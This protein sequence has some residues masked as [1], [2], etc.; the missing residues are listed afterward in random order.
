MRVGF[1]GR[2]PAKCI[3][4]RQTASLGIASLLFLDLREQKAKTALMQPFGLGGLD[5]AACFASQTGIERD[6][7]QKDSTFDVLGVA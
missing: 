3:T 7:G 4:L 5:L 2:G 1:G 6:L